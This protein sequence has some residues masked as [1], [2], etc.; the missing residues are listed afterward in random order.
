[1]KGPVFDLFPG[2]KPK[3]ESSLGENEQGATISSGSITATVSSKP[4]DF[5]IRFHSTD[6]K[7][8]LTSLLNRSVALAYDPA[9]SSPL[10]TGDMRTTKHYMLT[11]TTLGVGEQVYGLGERFGPLNRVGQTVSLW[12][13]D[14]GT[15]S[16]QSY[17]TIPFWLS[18]RGYGV[19]V[20][21]PQRVDLEIG[22]ER[23][24]RVQTSVEGQRLKWF[25]IHGPSPKDIVEKYTVLTG[26]PGKVPSWSFGKSSKPESMS[27]THR[28]R[29]MAKYVFHHG[30]RR[31]YC[32]RLPRRHERTRYTTRGLPLREFYVMA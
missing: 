12:N 7:E 24:C 31:E 25:I 4:H 1:M 3:V 26:K 27:C 29:S 11:Q 16:D 10:Q 23:C 32:C 30:L 8:K 22:S 13:A 18:N 6:G 19:F 20:D 5:D 2:G 14:G 28:D 21:T 17:K 15:S 9:T